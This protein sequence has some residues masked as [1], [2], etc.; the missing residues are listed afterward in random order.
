MAAV[1][2]DVFKDL[3]EGLSE[4]DDAA[5]SVPAI[6]EIIHESALVAFP[7]QI[8]KVTIFWLS[9]GSFS[10]GMISSPGTSVTS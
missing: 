7:N 4:I 2:S 9:I 8:I 6:D 10:S 5:V 3:I 1:V